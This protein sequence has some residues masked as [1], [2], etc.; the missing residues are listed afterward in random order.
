M[1][2]RA[3]GPEDLD[4]LADLKIAWSGAED[5]TT[6]NR[7]SFRD[8][9]V[10]WMARLGDAVACRIAVNDR[11]AVIGMAWL[12]VFER[13]PDLGDRRRRTADVQSVFVLPPH[14]GRGVGRALVDALLAEVDRRGIP[15]TTV[16]SS[17]GA[18]ALYE[19]AGFRASSELL[20]RRD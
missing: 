15:R 16:R 14:R 20:E 12:V 10:A 4:D 7:I 18:V 19:R 3:P 11:G 9:L 6:A 2:I 1:E 8:D 17:P 5:V 13:V